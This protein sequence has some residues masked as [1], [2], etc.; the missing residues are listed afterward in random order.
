VYAQD[1]PS[2]LPTRGIP[3]QIRALHWFAVLTSYSAPLKRFR[4]VLALG[5][6]AGAALALTSAYKVDLGFPPQLTA[7]EQPTY[8]AGTQLEVSSPAEP[9]YRSAVDVPVV[10]PTRTN[11]ENEEEPTNLVEQAEPSVAT[12]IAAANYYPHV[13]EGD[14]VK[15]LRE[16]LYGKIDGTVTASAIGA[17][18]TPNRQEPGR[19]PFIQIVASADSPANARALA[20]NTADAFIRFVRSEQ[21]RS[22]IRPAQRLVIEQLRRPERTFEV[23]GTSMNLPILIFV[24]LVAFA[25]AIAYLLDRLFPPRQAV[26]A[27]ADEDEDEV[28]R[29]DDREQLVAASGHEG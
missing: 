12:L 20:Q 26:V 25:V 17:T 10:T 14:Q 15:A 9:Y 1:Q 19:L 5:V 22:N 8:T 7:R 4:L 11:E 2:N 3:P 28:R 21:Q 24:A 27:A 16:R 29:L 6:V 13:I 23:G 18:I